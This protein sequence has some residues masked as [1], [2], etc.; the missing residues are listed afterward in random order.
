MGP[1]AERIFLN[2]LLMATFVL[3][4]AVGIVA[5]LKPSRFQTVA[6]VAN[7]CAVVLL[8]GVAGVGLASS[9]SSPKILAFAVIATFMATA[10]ANIWALR[11][12]RSNAG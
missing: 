7:V 4:Y 8:L 10:I 1:P 11:K 6:R 3:P 5:L 2:F 12:D 9:S